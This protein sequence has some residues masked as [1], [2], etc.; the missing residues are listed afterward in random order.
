MTGDVI[1][2]RQRRK[3]KGRAER[4]AEADRNAAAHG[5]PKHATRLARAREEKARLALDGHRLDPPGDSPDEDG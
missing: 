2:L 3:A 1:N 4:K 5:L